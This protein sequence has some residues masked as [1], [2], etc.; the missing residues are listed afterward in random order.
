MYGERTQPCRTPFLTRN[1]SDNSVPASWTLASCFL[2]SL[3]SKSIK[4]RWLHQSLMRGPNRPHTQTDE[5]MVVACQ[6]LNG[7]RDLTMPLSGM[8]WLMA[9]LMLTESRLN[10]SVSD[11][12]LDPNFLFTVFGSHRWYLRETFF[13][14]RQIIFQSNVTYS[15]NSQTDR[16][17]LRYTE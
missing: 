5:D 4:C 14:R 15:F 1:N 16:L 7:T 6:I 11:A 3:A 10:E 13:R 17:Q 8:V 2:Y 9:R 12:M